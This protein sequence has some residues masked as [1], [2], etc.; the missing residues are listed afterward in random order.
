MR[1]TSGPWTIHSER[2]VYRNPWM[3]VSEYDVT[4]PDGA[5]GLYGVMS[6]RGYAIGILP[7]FQDGTT[8]LVRQHRFTLD[9]PSLELP[10]GGGAKDTDPQESA[11]RELEEETGWRARSWSRFL[12]M[13]V[14]N[15]LTDEQAF[16]FFAWDLEPGK[17]A[18]EG[19]EADLIVQRTGFEEALQR[20]MAGEIR[21]AFTLAMLSK[22]DYMRRSGFLPHAVAAALNNR[23]AGR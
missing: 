21:D 14:S 22:A 12:E 13:D 4:R 11:A 16:A 10:E 20:A 2:V 6:P 19:S 8:L 18:L 9:A 1:K 23:E 15:S 7:I 3:R 17:Q 5:P